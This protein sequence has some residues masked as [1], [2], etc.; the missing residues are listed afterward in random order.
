MGLQ[1]RYRAA[2]GPEL[3]SVGI[4]AKLFSSVAESRFADRGVTGFA[5][6]HRKLIAHPESH[7]K[8]V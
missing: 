6:Q 7:P 2:F 8:T 4:G 1:F 5:N 3:R